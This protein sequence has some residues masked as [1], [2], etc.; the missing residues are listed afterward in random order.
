MGKVPKLINGPVLINIAPKTPT[1]HFKEYE[2]MGY[3]IAIYPPITITATYA[4]IKAKL[5]E[6]KEKGIVEQGA[7]GGVPF[8]EL[9]DF[10]GIEKYR[11]LEK[12]LFK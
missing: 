1:L 6:F 11:T 5:S 12:D 4:A 8:D 9:L 7:H 2:E 10:L 3:S